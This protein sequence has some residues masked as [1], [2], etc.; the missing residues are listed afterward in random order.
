L[1]QQVF[2]VHKARQELK[3]CK[4]LLAFKDSKEPLQ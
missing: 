1:E 2:K 3:V 4:V